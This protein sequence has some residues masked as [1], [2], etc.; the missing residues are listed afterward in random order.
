MSKGAAR[1]AGFSWGHAEEVSF[2]TVWLAKN[3][4]DAAEDLINL[5]ENDMI[6]SPANIDD[7]I[8]TNKNGDLDPI[9]SGA[10]LLDLNI[11]RSIVLED[12]FLP[13]FLFPFVAHLPNSILIEA[14]NFSALSINGMVDVNFKNLPLRSEVLKL[15][16]T[17]DNINIVQKHISKRCEIADDVWCPLLEIIEKQLCANTDPCFLVGKSITTAECGFGAYIM[18]FIFG[19][20]FPHKAIYVEHLEKFPKTKNWA[21]KTVEPA[22]GKWFDTQPKGLWHGL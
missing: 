10:A 5:L 16:E 3:G 17:S 6:Y 22:F 9:K 19:N 2:A 4:F 13:C 8:W 1:G 18:K 14:N 15:S 21:H 11:K 12:V 20:Y 7:D